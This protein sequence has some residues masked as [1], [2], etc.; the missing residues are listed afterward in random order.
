MIDKLKKLWQLFVGLFI[1]TALAGTPVF[2]PPPILDFVSISQEQAYSLS[3][4][5]K[6]QHIKKTKLKN[7][8]Y[9]VTEYQR[10]DDA[11]SK[12]YVG[13][14]LHIDDG[15]IKQDIDFGP[16]ERNFY[17]DRYLIPPDVATS[18]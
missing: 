2:S 6:Y 8:T 17:L 5:G 13:W 12:G 18:T 15:V 11:V 1:G 10:G 7:V 14:V 16:E 4:T 3:T 9:S